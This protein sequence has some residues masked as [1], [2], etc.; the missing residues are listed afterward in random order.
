M[1]YLLLFIMVSITVVIVRSV[2]HSY[3]SSKRMIILKLLLHFI[4]KEIR[5]LVYLYIALVGVYIFLER[6]Y[7]Y[8]IFPANLNSLKETFLF[9]YHMN[10]NEFVM[11][12]YS[13]FIGIYIIILLPYRLLRLYSNVIKHTNSLDYIHS[14]VIAKLKKLKDTINNDNR[15]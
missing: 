3:T 1:I 13:L 10:S 11:K 8:N 14:F 7:K 2:K 5:L 12:M 6:I 4:F 9:I 15:R